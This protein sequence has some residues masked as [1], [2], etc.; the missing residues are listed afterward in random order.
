[1][2]RVTSGWL[3][4]C[5]VACVLATIPAQTQQTAVPD[6]PFDAD[7]DFLKLPPEMHLGEAAGVAVNS[8][9]HVFV[10]NRGNTSGPA[11]GA[12][13]AQ[14]LEFDAAGKFVREIGHN[15]YA[16]S[17]AHTVRIDR[18]DNI[19]AVDK[20]S[21]MVV[22]FTPAGR[23][24]MVFGRKKEASDEALPWAR[25]T[26]PLAPING[27]FRQPTDVTW[28]GQGNIFISD[29]YIN[30]RIAKYDRNGDW[31]AS[32]GT[33]GTGT[34]QF[35]TPHSIASDAQG[36]LYVADRGNLRIQ[37]LDP[38]GNFLRAITLGVP[39][40]PDAKP[41]IDNPPGPDSPPQYKAGSPWAVCIT[42]GPTQY[43]YASDAFPGRIYKMTLDGKILGVLGRAGKQAKQF[44]WIHE[45]ACPSENT[46]FVAEVL[47]WRVQKL[48]LRPGPTAR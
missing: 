7:T 21:D 29:G 5:A 33:P 45:M 2:N 48:T 42:P 20:G 10:F 38:N 35:N 43:L 8:Q 22:K 44:G 13:A 28:D 17:Y 24:S 39:V 1:M 31:V 46:L 12:T 14:L 27:R 15:L 30:S 11:F 6:I 34:G 36:N 26:P 23:V 18:N 16:F 41:A 3:A 37:V 32:F 9:G 25:V 47:N 4:A 40:P 19:W